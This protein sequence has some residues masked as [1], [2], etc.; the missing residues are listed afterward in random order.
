VVWLRRGRRVE[1]AHDRHGTHPGA[2]SLN[3]EA[4]YNEKGNMSK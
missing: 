2:S 3:W 4:V 1:K